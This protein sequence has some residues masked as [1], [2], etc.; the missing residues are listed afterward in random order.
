[1]L[2]FVKILEYFNKF[3]LYFIFITF[4][5]EFNKTPPIHENCRDVPNSINAGFIAVERCKQ[6]NGSLDILAAIFKTR[7]KLQDTKCEC[8][9]TFCLAMQQNHMMTGKERAAL[10]LTL[11]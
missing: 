2:G 7:A 6:D 10:I 3:F 8:L 1:M 9:S 4:V 11:Q 5:Q